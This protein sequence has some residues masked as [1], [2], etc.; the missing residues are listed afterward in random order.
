MRRIPVVIGLILLAATTFAQQNVPTP[1]R[2]NS[3]RAADVDGGG[4]APASPPVS[5]TIVV[6]TPP[7]PRPAIPSP[8][9]PASDSDTDLGQL[10]RDVSARRQ[11]AE[12]SASAFSSAYSP[13]Q[14]LAYNQWV[15][16]YTQGAYAWHH[17]STVIIFFVVISVVLSGVVLAAWQ[18]RSWLGRVAAYDRVFLSRLEQGHEVSAA[19]IAETGKAGSHELNLQSKAVALTT[20]YV[21]VVILGL[22][23]GF[24]LAYLLLV[25]PIL[26]GP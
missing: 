8:E 14:L 26:Q 22:S 11:A 12:A 1:I 25:Y 5:Q 9:N 13:E 17:T 20:P 24:F 7:T 15:I 6:D 18:L 2:G 21:G 19:L 23:M 4:T 3:S 16:N 10:I